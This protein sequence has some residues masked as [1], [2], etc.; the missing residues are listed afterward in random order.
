MPLHFFRFCGAGSAAGVLVAGMRVADFRAP[1]NKLIR[2]YSVACRGRRMSREPA[3][4]KDRANSR[5]WE[6]ERV[7]SL[8][9][10][11]M[12]PSEQRLCDQLEQLKAR[13]GQREG[14]LRAAR[15][16]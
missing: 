9:T 4:P 16:S 3:L 6:P 11:F 5:P 7:R 2:K 14:E 12:T 13:L 8:K 15:P 10:L 1:A